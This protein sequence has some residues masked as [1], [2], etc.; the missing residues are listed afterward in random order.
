[1]PH[2][3]FTLIKIFCMVMCLFQA[4]IASAEFHGTLTGTTNYVYKMYSKSNNDPAIQANLDY[5]HPSGFYAGTSV[6]SFNIGKSEIDEDF[7]FSN[8]A[9]VEISPYLGWSFKLDDNWR[10]DT[11]YIRYFYDNKVYEFSGDYNEFYFSMHFKEMLSANISFTDDLYG[12]GNIALFYELTGR[13]PITDFL[14]FSSTFG[15]GQTKFVLFDDYPY[16]NAGLTGRY[17]FIAL[18]LRYYDAKEI[19]FPHPFGQP[20]HPDKLTATVVFTISVGF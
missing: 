18:D 9:R 5:Q 7:H 8:Q 19:H 13:Y 6:S 10:L 4:T 16:W 3:P 1:M 14:E 11:Q 20:N 17:K 2:K 12:I 15:Y